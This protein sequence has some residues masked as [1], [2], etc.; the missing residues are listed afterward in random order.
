MNTNPECL[1]C[2][3]KGVEKLLHQHIKDPA[4]LDS[5][6]QQLR[7]EIAGFREDLPAPVN[8]RAAYMKLNSMTGNPDPYR[9]VKDKSTECAWRV[10]G[11][12]LPQILLFPDPFEAA[13]RLTIAGNIIDFGANPSL[14]FQHAEK[15]IRSAFTEYLD[16][17]AIKKLR[18]KMDEA[19]NILYIMDNCGEAV[20]DRLLAAFYT[21]KITLAV[22]GK[23]ILNDITR[24]EIESSGLDILAK[25]IV[26]TGDCTPGISLEHSS[27][28]FREAFENADLIVAKGQGNYETLEQMHDKNI[29]FLFRAKCPVVI[30]TLNKEPLAMCIEFS[31]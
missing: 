29:I 17:E 7:Q 20:F 31:C 5:L 2:F 11:A 18:R 12:I 10:T 27:A 9:E 19:K 4:L 30:R 13:L 24:R 3:S 6:M 15:M 22:R 8:A 23:P 26:D 1:E 25:R 28:E 14:T 21:D 16:P